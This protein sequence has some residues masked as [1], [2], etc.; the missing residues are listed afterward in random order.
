MVTKLKGEPHVKKVRKKV[1]HLNEERPSCMPGIMTAI[2]FSAFFSLKSYSRN[3]PRGIW[4]DRITTA[5]FLVSLIPDNCQ[6][7]HR[8]VIAGRIPAECKEKKPTGGSRG[9]KATPLEVLK[10]EI[11]V[12][13]MQRCLNR[14]R[15]QGRR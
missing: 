13:P 8:W 9:Y 3:T 15:A 10:V 11:M 7:I 2:L 1:E 12:H 14:S 5:P 6:T 4:D